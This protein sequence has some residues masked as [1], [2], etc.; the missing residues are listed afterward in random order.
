MKIKLNGNEVDAPHNAVIS[1][2]LPH[3]ECLVAIIRNRR[4]QE[5]LVDTYKLQIG[6]ETVTLKIEN[7]EIWEAI[8]EK[9]EGLEIAWRT[10]RV[11]AF[12]PF[13]CELKCSTIQH[14]YEPGEVVLSL[15]GG[16]KE[17]TFLMF[18][19]TRYPISHCTIA[20]GVVGRVIEGFRALRTLEIGDKIEKIIPVFGRDT[21]GTKIR[22]KRDDR[23]LEGDEI[24]TRA[25]I[26]LIKELPNASEYAMSVF[27]RNNRVEEVTN[28]YIRF[29]GIKGIRIGEE[30][31]KKRIRGA[32]TIRRTGKNAGDIYIYL[33]DRMP[34]KDHCVVG[35]V[36]SG[37]ELL[38]IAQKGDRINI[39]TDPSKIDLVG[40]T[41]AEAQE[42]LAKKG[43]KQV[44]EGDKEDNAVVVSQLPETTF[45]ILSRGEVATFGV[46]PNKIV[47]VKIFDDVA[48]KTAQY[49]R[50]A[51]G[52]VGKK[53]G[54]LPLYFKTKDLAIFKP[55]I[56]FDEPLIP[57][58]TPKGSVN[59]GEIGITNMSR[60]HAGLIGVRF[61]ESK[62]FGP[63]AERFESTNIVGL[64][65]E[66]LEVVKASREGDNIYI[67]EVE[68]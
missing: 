37:I 22:A 27:E 9:L 33:R 16:S 43:L 20:D 57:E 54:K 10:K 42:L 66:N 63:T 62:E 12:G 32:V 17:S 23:L 58:N 3:E 14:E 13:S 15:A 25:F 50:I 6:R 34:H 7:R 38:E 19:V 4:D 5:K 30:N 40:L 41:Q 53:V 24:Y 11:I 26:K 1:D 48:P 64:V 39:L 52:L 65:L 8:E 67:V 47:K 18:T 29:K 21:S 46:S 51:S 61:S 31:A 35:F 60:K 49:F 36:E 44:R 68:R 55:N 2:I 56:S 45:E 59:A 28:T